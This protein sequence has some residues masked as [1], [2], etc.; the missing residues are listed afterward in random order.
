MADEELTKILLPMVDDIAYMRGKMENMEGAIVR[1]TQRDDEQDEK[2]HK[3]ENKIYAISAIGPIL[4]GLVMFK[5]NLKSLLG[6]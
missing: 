3:I 1:R 6:L 4:V 5:D 2:I